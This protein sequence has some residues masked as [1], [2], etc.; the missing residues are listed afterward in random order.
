MSSPRIMSAEETAALNRVR[1]RILAITFLSVALHG[2][3]GLV[4]VGEIVDGQGRRDAGIGLTVMSGVLGVAT[5][6]ATRAI[7]GARPFSILWALVGLAPMAF[8]LTRIL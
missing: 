7:L 4:V 1:R 3:I 8:G 6:I 5:S 2:V